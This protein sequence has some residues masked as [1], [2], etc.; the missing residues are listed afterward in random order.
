MAIITKNKYDSFLIETLLKDKFL[1]SGTLCDLLSAQ[2]KVT[3]TNARKIVERSVSKGYIKS[4]APTTF[5]KGQFVYFLPSEKLNKDTIKKIA[6]KFRPPLYRLLECLDSNDGVIS[7]Y[8]ALK[9]TASPIE[10]LGSKIDILDDLIEV[11]KKYDLVYLTTDSNNVKYII[12]QSEKEKETI[13]ISS[14]YSK[15]KLD[16]IFVKDILDWLIKSNLVLSLNNIYRSK[17]TP[18]IGAVH[19]NILWDA[20][21]YTKTTG[22]NPIATQLATGIEKQTLIVVDIVLSR[23]YEQYDLDGFLSRIQIN[24]N[25]VSKGTRKVM[26]II[27]YKSCTD[28]V[29]NAIK[30]LGFLCYDIGSIFGSN[31]F[32]IL[33]NI[34]KL[35]INQNFLENQEFEKTIEETLESI[36]NS[37][38]EDQLK[39][40]KGTLF[41][42]MMY[43]IL[44]HQ[45]PNA[46][47]KASFYYSKRTVN[48]EDN[49][50]I[51]EG[52][53]YDY[54]IKSSNPKE[55]IVVELK[56][57]H[58]KYEIPLGDYQTK[59][60]VKWFF[61][62]TL[63]FIKEK[64]KTDIGDGY[65]FK[66]AYI[67]SSKFTEEALEN[68]NKKNQSS[69]KPKKIDVYYDR[70]KLVNLLSENDFNTLKAI[71]EKFY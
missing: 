43:Q 13:L 59:S 36:K 71:L 6:K 52:Y 50:E 20:F 4:S 1:V 21:G 58:S 7:Y 38:Q 54:I 39:A 14:H 17:N 53:E 51:K 25:S 3:N 66:G 56:G 2:Y 65:I 8:E 70:E 69:L 41:E 62:K 60:T 46:D 61:N 31:I 16:A 57:Y 9:I 37:G 26:P 34:S 47:I 32:Y 15:L 67:T 35:Q 55:I 12:H 42:V 11:L 44:K 33:N 5:G 10:R 48:Q 49:S 27:V 29:L 28:Y 30:S 19:N 24:L 63:P 23:D 68:L 64:F 22:I 45:Y 18:S 40:L